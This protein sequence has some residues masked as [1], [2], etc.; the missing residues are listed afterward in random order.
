MNVCQA[1]Y[2]TY[3]VVADFPVA[4]YYSGRL[5]ADFLL[6]GISFCTSQGATP[7]THLQRGD[8]DPISTMVNM[9][10]STVRFL[11]AFK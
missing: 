4:W 1:M 5:D 9:T 11:C 3:E 10:K 6:L 2:F 7:V 8:N